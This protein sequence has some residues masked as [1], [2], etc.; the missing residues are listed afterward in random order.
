VT[1]KANNTTAVLRRN[2][3]S[4]PQ[5]IKDMCYKT[6]VRSQLENVATVW[7]SNTDNNIAKLEAV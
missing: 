1:K 3:S 2:L 6:F 7:D 5:H 4:C